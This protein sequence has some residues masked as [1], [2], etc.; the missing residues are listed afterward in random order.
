M[1]ISSQ[2]NRAELLY[3]LYLERLKLSQP[4]SQQIFSDPGHH[5][6]WH[7]VQVDHSCRDVH[8]RCPTHSLI[9]LQIAEGQAA[10]RKRENLR[11]KVQPDQMLKELKKKE[12]SE[13]LKKKL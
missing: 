10:I 2:G 9:G 6:S 3:S 8:G 1:V 4:P 12:Q 11:G 5:P 7:R 13:N